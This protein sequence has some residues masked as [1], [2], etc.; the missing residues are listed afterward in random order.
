MASVWEVD[1]SILRH[2][3]QGHEGGWVCEAW[4]SSLGTYVGTACYDHQVR[5][6]GVSSGTLLRSL[7]GHS[8]AVLSVCMSED[9]RIL[10]SAGRD[11]SLRFWDVATGSTSRVAQEHVLSVLRVRFCGSD[12]VVSAG[13]DRSIRIWDVETGKS[14]NVLNGHHMRPVTGVCSDEFGRVVA[15]CSWDRSIVL[16]DV[17]SGKMVGEMF[18]HGDWIYSVSMSADARVIASCSH[19][20]TVRLW[21]TETGKQLQVLEGHKEPVYAVSMTPDGRRVASGCL[22]QTVRVWG[23]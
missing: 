5:L 11:G 14:V 8:D 13:F 1:S 20:R 7:K 16:W 23:A 19:D 22:D 4:L 9:E 6:Y 15:S 2:S 17:N 10:V 3:L 21:S 18:G 12:R